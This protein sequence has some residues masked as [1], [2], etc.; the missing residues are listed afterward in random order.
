MPPKSV[1]LSDQELD[2]VSPLVAECE[3]DFLPWVEQEMVLYNIA[4][5]VNAF[6]HI[7]FATGK[8]NLVVIVLEHVIHSPPLLP[9]S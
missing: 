6:S 2:A 8:I 5:T 4:K 1:V 9:A 7:G 3:H